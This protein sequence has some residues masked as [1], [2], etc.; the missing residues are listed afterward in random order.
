MRPVLYR[1]VPGR[2]AGFSIEA[3]ALYLHTL[4]IPPLPPPCNPSLSHSLA[5]NLESLQKGGEE[6][7]RKSRLCRCRYSSRSQAKSPRRALGSRK[8]LLTARASYPHA[9]SRSANTQPGLRPLLLLL[10]LLLPLLSLP[11]HDTPPRSDYITATAQNSRP[12]LIHEHPPPSMNPFRKKSPASSSSEVPA[13]APVAEPLDP[14]V[15]AVLTDT[16]VP[17]DIWTGMLPPPRV[18]GEPPPAHSA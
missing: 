6:K 2:Q 3:D 16:G 11:H 18:P 1:T 15:V 10:L 14:R 5:A 13:P 4:H 12:N 7:K 17:V 9:C 8:L